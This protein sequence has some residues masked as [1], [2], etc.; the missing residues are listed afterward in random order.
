MHRQRSRPVLAAG[1]VAGPSA[2][3]SR[4]STRRALAAAG[5][6]ARVSDL[7][8]ARGKRLQ[9]ASAGSS[10]KLVASPLSGRTARKWRSS[11]VATRVV[12]RCAARAVFFMG[13]HHTTCHLSPGGT[14]GSC[15]R[16]GELAERRCCSGP[17]RLIRAF[18]WSWTHAGLE[19]RPGQNRD[20]RFL[21]D[22]S[23]RPT[24]K[25]RVEWQQ[26]SI[27]QLG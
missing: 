6:K 26:P 21:L 1:V 9:S 25:L 10:V 16:R 19:A 12:S 23:S 17:Y 22:D 11:S 18:V 8:P 14:G 24:R 15:A 2:R 20:E 4:I 13:R 27:Q 3:D 7:V 5:T